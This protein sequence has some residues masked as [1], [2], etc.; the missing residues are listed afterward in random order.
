MS[1]IQK[2]AMAMATVAMTS[3]GP[4]LLRAQAPVPKYT[5]AEVVAVKVHERLLVVRNTDGREE[6]LE[7]DDHVAGFGDLRAGDQVILSLRGEPGR[8]RIESFSKAGA[9]ARNVVVEAPRREAS[10]SVV[11]SD[12][13][14]AEDAFDRRVATL[15]QQ[16]S[17]VDGLWS[18]FK[19]SCSVILRGGD[20]EGARE[21]LSLW[22]DQV[23]VDLSN[24]ACRD[25]F[26]QIVGLGQGVNTG[27]ASAQDSARSAMEAGRIREVLRRHSLDWAG[28]GRT[29]PEL[30]EPQ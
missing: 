9:P 7:L 15:A 11:V 17:R 12:E 6:T 25:L 5:N 16:A 29:A 30:R 22:D 13:V 21:W 2:L 8:S 3:L 14:R 19:T 23:Q 4:G 26:N 20:Y 10:A 24:G 28:W 18:G 27:V 1:A